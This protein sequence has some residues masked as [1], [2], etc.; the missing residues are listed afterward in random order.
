MENEELKSQEMLNVECRILNVEVEYPFDLRHSTFDIRYFLP[1]LILH[2]K[3][4][5][6]NFP[7]HYLA[8][9]CV[10]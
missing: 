7:G 4:F 2:L 8:N 1:F 9:N 3:F 5:I 10:K 6:S